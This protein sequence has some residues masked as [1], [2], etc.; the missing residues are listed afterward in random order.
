MNTI[1]VNI[2][3]VILCML[4]S[5]PPSSVVKWL[6]GNMCYL[7]PTGGTPPPG[8]ALTQALTYPAFQNLVQPPSTDDSHLLVM[9]LGIRPE[10]LHEIHLSYSD[11]M[12][13]VLVRVDSE[14]QGERRRLRACG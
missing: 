5:T 2:S 11:W 14:E 6:L 10:L 8:V 1:K 3:N 13:M 9:I 12:H 7:H 4:N